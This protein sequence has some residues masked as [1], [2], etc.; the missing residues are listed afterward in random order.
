MKHLAQKIFKDLE[1][2][3]GAVPDQIDKEI[4]NEGK[5]LR[6]LSIQLNFMNTANLQRQKNSSKIIKSERV[7]NGRTEK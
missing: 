6:L 7:M 3:N 1:E 5:Y 2:E 4:P